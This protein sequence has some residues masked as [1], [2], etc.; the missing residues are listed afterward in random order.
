MSKRILVVEDQ[1]DNRQ[2]IRECWPPPIM[3]SPRP[4]TANKPWKFMK[5]LLIAAICTVPLYASAQ[6]PDTAKLKADAQKIA[7][8]IRGDKAK[9]ETY[10]QLDSLGDLIDVAAQAK[11]RKMVETLSQRADDLEK[12][13]GSEYRALFDAL[14][15]AD[16]NS[17]QDILSIFDELD[18]I[19]RH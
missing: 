14:N 16:P 1:P 2:I 5:R 10:C 15:D 4:K 19:C 17:V 8:T 7:S 18:E 9:T 6:Q 13:L 3:R 12:Q 11:D